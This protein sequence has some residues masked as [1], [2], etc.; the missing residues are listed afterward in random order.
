MRVRKLVNSSLKKAC[1]LGTKC[2]IKK[3]IKFVKVKKSHFSEI[4]I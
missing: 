4:F 1:Q 2:E 3:S